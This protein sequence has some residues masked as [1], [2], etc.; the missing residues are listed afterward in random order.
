MTVDPNAVKPAGPG[1][2]AASPAQPAPS[3]PAGQAATPAPAPAAQPQVPPVQGVKPDSMVPL[4]ALHEERNKRQAL[5]AELD[6]L[7]VTVESLKSQPQQHQQAPQQQVPE[8]G[9]PTNEQIEKLWEEDPKQAVR[10]EIMMAFNWYDQMSSQMEQVADQIANQNPDFNLIRGQVMNYVRS[11][12]LERRNAQA[13]QQ[14]YFTIRGQNVDTILKQREAEMLAKM[15]IP[16]GFQMPNGITPP[17]PSSP[18]GSVSLTQDQINVAEMMG[19]TPEQYASQIKT[20][21]R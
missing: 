4:S 8:H 15:Q 1:V 6:Q 20:G 11:L 14:A 18:G 10:T 12:P 7:R 17:S 19:L 5:A 21:G 2:P 16:A 13:V 3:A 9:G